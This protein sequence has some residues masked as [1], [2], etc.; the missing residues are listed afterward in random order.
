MLEAMPSIQGE[1]LTI[2]HGPSAIPR[3][4]QA[5]GAADQGNRQLRLSGLERPSIACR[6]TSQMCKRRHPWLTDALALPPLLPDPY[7]AG[8]SQFLA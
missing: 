4:Q 7:N 5:S 8:Q 1:L 6:E 2:G 3:V